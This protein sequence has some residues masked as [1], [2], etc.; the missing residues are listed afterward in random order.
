MATVR[1]FRVGDGG[2]LVEAWRRSAPYDPVTPARFRNL[3][4]LDP[5]FDPQGLRVAVEDDRVV[6]AAYAV[7]RTV[8]MVGDDLEPGMGWLPFFF[9]APEARRQGVGGAL[10]DSALG[11]LR[12]HGVGTVEFAGYTPNYVLPGLDAEAYPEAR[13]LLEH[14]GFR[15]RYEAVAMDRS[16]VDYTMPDAVRERVAALT[17][18]GYRFGTPTDDDLVEL[19]ALARDEF[20]PDWGR[21]IRE[22]VTAGTPT[23]RIVCVREPGGVLVGWAQHEAYEGATERF[24]PFGV[25]ETRRGTGLG[26]VLL[27]LT[28]ERMRALG[29]HSAWFLWTGE[30]SAA[31]QLYLRT[32]FTVT[33]RFQ[34]MR[35]A[36][37]D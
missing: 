5:N 11:W 29:A 34:V 1:E 12:G 10:L 3:V 25:L 8:A 27:H 19:V 9:V 37:T 33:R 13:K 36:L 32:G 14:K 17:A 21:A 18:E 24:G 23:D 16:L 22:C 30:K 31:G 20:N 35:A 2:S 6:G 7:R 4:L 28:L 26:K 15:T